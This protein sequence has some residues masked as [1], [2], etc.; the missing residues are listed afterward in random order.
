MMLNRQLGVTS[1]SLLL[2]VGLPVAQPEAQSPDTKDHESVRQ[3]IEAMYED[4]GRARVQID[5]KTIE[6]ILTDD[7]FVLLDGETITRADFIE[8]VTRANRGATLSRF[9]ADVL[10]PAGRRG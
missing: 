2:L 5:R 3:E 4:W 8:M 6:R 10:D 1:V 9:D 7:F